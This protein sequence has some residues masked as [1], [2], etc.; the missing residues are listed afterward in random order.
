MHFIRNSIG[1]ARPYPCSICEKRYS[2][3]AKV[4]KHMKIHTVRSD[5]AVDDEPP[6][7]TTLPFVCTPCNKQF[8]TQSMYNAHLRGKSHD[9][10]RSFVCEICSQGFRDLKYLLNH[11]SQKHHN[12]LNINPF[13]CKFCHKVLSS[14]R[15]LD[16]HT[17]MLHTKNAKFKCPHCD[18]QFQHKS[19][20]DVHLNVHTKSQHFLCPHC[21]STFLKDFYLKNH[22]Q[23]VH[24][25]E[26]PYECKFCQRKFSGMR[27]NVLPYIKYF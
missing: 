25:G 21:P 6:P 22:I 24:S 14:A 27:I 9:N 13:K 20:R 12:E 11:Q 1:I 4:E 7:E 8:K 19:A 15:T 3:P 26:K 18:V 23:R 17:R 2:S 5:V 16:D 10:I